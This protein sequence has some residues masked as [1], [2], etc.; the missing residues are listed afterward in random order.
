MTYHIQQE[1]ADFWAAPKYPHHAAKPVH[2]TDELVLHIAMKVSRT[3]K[4]LVVEQFALQRDS[5]T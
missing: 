2:V 1:H 5:N 3:G 4:I